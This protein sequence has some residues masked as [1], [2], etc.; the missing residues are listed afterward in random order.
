MAAKRV[1][2]LQRRG[3]G[4]AQAGPAWLLS[5]LHYCCCSCHYC[6]CCCCCYYNNALRTDDVPAEG[7]VFVQEGP[8]IVFIMKICSFI[9]FLNLLPLFIFIF[10]IIIMGRDR[11]TMFQRRAP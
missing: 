4:G 7:A 1:T 2:I 6:C 3:G 10:M 5:L 11:A 9:H 8:H